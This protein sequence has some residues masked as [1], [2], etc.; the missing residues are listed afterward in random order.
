MALCP[1][2]R[3]EASLSFRIRSSAVLSIPRARPGR[4]EG[5]SG[6]SETAMHSDAPPTTRLITINNKEIENFLHSLQSRMSYEFVA[7]WMKGVC[8]NGYLFVSIRECTY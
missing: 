7:E 6:S 2:L 5:G 3:E 8:R 4:D 1:T